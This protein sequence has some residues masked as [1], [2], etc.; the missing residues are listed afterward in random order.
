[1]VTTFS[2]ALEVVLLKACMRCVC[3]LHV[4]AGCGRVE[5]T[6]SHVPTS[7][8]GY[9]EAASHFERAGKIWMNALGPEHPKVATALCN[10]A[11]LLETQVESSYF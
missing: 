5:T 1:M 4:A 2:L 6:Q 7:Q 8:G 3:R 10:Q 9:K 11:E